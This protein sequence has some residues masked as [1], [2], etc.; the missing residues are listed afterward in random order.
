MN[1]L[2]LKSEHGG[3]KRAEVFFSLVQSARRLGIDPF[4]YLTDVIERATGEWNESD[5]GAMGV[6]ACALAYDLNKE[7]GV[8]ER[9]RT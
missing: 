3:G 8:L 7:L 4:T 6:I 1:S 5:F 9:G 2:F